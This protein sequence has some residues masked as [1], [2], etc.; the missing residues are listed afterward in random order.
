[1]G[2]YHFSGLGLSPGAVTLPLST[3]YVLLVGANVKGYREAKEFFKFSGEKEQT[4][5]GGP[6]AIIIFTT[7]EII[8]AGEGGAQLA[9]RHNVRSNLFGKMFR[10]RTPVVK[11]IAKYLSLMY[12]YLEEQGLE[13]FYDGK[14]IKHIYLV[15]VEHKD[16]NDAFTKIG[17]AMRGHIDKEVWVN[18]IAGT[19]QQ[20]IAMLNTGLFFGT[21]TRYYYIFQ[22]DETLLDSIYLK[23][24]ITEGVVERLLQ[25]WSSLPIFFVGRYGFLMELLKRFRKYNNAIPGSVLKKDVREYE[26]KL[27]KLKGYLYYD[28]KKGLFRPTK[29]LEH[30]I[31]LYRGIFRENVRNHSEWKRWCIEKGILYE[32]NLDGTVEPVT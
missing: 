17:V 29:E 24:E 18:M 22:Y 11:V 21:A 32:L 3:V 10:A 12:D 27:E 25:Q 13:P 19:N 5:K 28:D 9:L 30:I 26:V 16:Y 31:S 23:K 6:E 14:W 15:Q 1:M 2:V 4:K 7:K 8:G 20:T